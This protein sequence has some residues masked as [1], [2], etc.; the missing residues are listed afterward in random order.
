MAA[1]RMFQRQS[2]RA[3]P[4][5]AMPRAMTRSGRRPML[6]RWTCTPPAPRGLPRRARFAPPP[7]TT[8][9]TV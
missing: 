8:V 3:G 7:A 6:G 5:R 2:T 1:R 4:S 9:T